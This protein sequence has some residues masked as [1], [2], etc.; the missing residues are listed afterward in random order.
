MKR[1]YICILCLLGCL[2]LT[3]CKKITIVNEVINRVVN[4]EENI[5]IL[6][7]EDA[8]VEAT[9]ISKK[10]VIGISSKSG[11]LQ[12]ESFGSGVIIKKEQVDDEKYKYYVLT[13]KHVACV[14]SILVTLTIYL[15]DEDTYAA[16]VE[17]YDENMDIAIISFETTR[18][19][20]VAKVSTDNIEVGR[21]VIAVGNPYELKNYYNSV[22]VGN[23]SHLER[24]LEETNSKDETV[25]NKYIQHNAEINSGN[26]GGGLFNIKGELIGINT[27]KVVNEKIEGMSFAI[28]TIEF[29]EKYNKYF[30]K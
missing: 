4:Y 15:G 20:D 17:I 22:T 2:T 27:W 18:I 30:E 10:T 16:K 3:S 29:Y 26:S 28:S 19:L 11:I 7:F 14:E 1:I 6:D 8:I 23:I 9:S 12:A 25:R 13:N 21:F 24:Y 5:S